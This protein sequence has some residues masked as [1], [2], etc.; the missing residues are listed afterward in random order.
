MRAAI[1]AGGMGP[2]GEIMALRR[3]ARRAGNAQKRELAER[4]MQENLGFDGSIEDMNVRELMYFMDY[5]D[6]LE[7][8]LEDQ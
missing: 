3:T 8:A 2:E 7:Y 5:I 6:Y 1:D 4:A